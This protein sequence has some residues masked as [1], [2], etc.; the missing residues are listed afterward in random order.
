MSTILIVGGNFINKGAQ[1]MLFCLVDFLRGKYPDDEIIVLDL[2]P[3]LTSSEKQKYSFTILNMHVRTLFRI[4]FPFLKLWFKKSAKSDRESDIINAFK[5]ARVMYDISGYGV[6]S[7]QQPIIWTIATLLPFR[8]ARKHRV[9][10]ILLPQSL[11]P[12][13]YSGWRRW[14]LFPFVKN[15]LNYIETIFIREPESRDYL[16]SFRTVGIID[17]PDL[18]LQSGP[19]HPERLFVHPVQSTASLVL[20]PGAVALIPNRQLNRIWGEQTTIDRFAQIIK[21]ILDSGHQVCILKHS[22]DD[23]MLCQALFKQFAGNERVF[24]EI[25][26]YEPHEMEHV[27]QA[28]A[29]VVSARYHGLVHALRIGIPVFSVGWAIKYRRLMKLM[30][31]EEMHL[32]HQEFADGPVLESKLNQFLNTLDEARFKIEV[33]V[34]EIRNNS[35]FNKY[36]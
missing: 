2:F 24:L 9:P 16:A 8:M 13:R 23:I 17:S 6:S 32:G 3:S 28:F 4:S 21:I 31:Q 29:G 10:C 22:A 15:Y 25:S 7:H 14:F 11:G 30:E 26:D 1:S 27:M 33:K 36:L 35:L 18:V 12:F 19:M 34:Q 20:Y 5:S